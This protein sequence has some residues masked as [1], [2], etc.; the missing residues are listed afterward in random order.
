MDFS[1]EQEPDTLEKANDLNRILA[2]ALGHLLEKNEGIV[3]QFT[4]DVDKWL[5][6][7]H[8]GMINVAL[9]PEGQDISLEGEIMSD[10]ML[11]WLTDKES[12]V[13]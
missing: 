13:Q 6:S 12:M 11:Y 5:I 10:G 9:I 8:N 4:D 2:R 1:W 7:N 3:I